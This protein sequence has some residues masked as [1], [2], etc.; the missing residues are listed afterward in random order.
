MTYK[1]W[2]DCGSLL[3]FA[4]ITMLAYTD[5]AIH[6]CQMIGKLVQDAIL[7]VGGLSCHYQPGLSF[8]FSSCLPMQN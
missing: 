7:I 6:W 5:L 3:D 2:Y 8:E 1:A 4:E